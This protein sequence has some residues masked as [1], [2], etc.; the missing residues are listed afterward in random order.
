MLKMPPTM[1]L[2]P[3]SWT[4]IRPS[5]RST[6]SKYCNELNGKSFYYQLRNRIVY[7]HSLENIAKA[8]VYN[9]EKRRPWSMQDAK[10]RWEEVKKQVQAD[11][12]K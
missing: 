2:K 4:R 1:S 8:Q 6:G 11:K 5:R 9:P 12:E 10:E 3:R 7:F